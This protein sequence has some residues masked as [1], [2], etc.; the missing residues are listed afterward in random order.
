MPV[1]VTPEAGA[2]LDSLVICDYLDGLAQPRLIPA[3]QPE[4]RPER[5]ERPA[6]HALE[7]LDSLAVDIARMVDPAAAAD[8][9]KRYERGERNVF[10][11][12]IYTWQGQRMFDEIRRR[13]DS[14]VE[15][16]DTVSRYLDEFERLLAEASRRE[17][18]AALAQT[19]LGSETGKVYTMLAHAASRFE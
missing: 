5:A 17:D 16:Q 11:K 12:K 9:W 4:R 7:S 2:I 14:D 1:L 18:G 10:T 13:Y 3:A 15:F 6:R 19:Y 8:L